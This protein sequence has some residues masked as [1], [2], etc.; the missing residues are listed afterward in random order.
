MKIFL[1]IRNLDEVMEIL[2]NVDNDS[3]RYMEVVF[4]IVKRIPKLSLI[5]SKPTIIEKRIDQFEQ[6]NDNKQLKFIEMWNKIQLEINYRKGLNKFQDI[7]KLSL[8]HI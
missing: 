7:V 8:I 4:N 3:L 2:N 6:Y 1:S 5:N